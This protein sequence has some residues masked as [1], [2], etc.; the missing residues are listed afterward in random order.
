MNGHV[1]LNICSSGMRNLSIYGKLR[2]GLKPTDILFI[3]LIHPI[4]KGTLLISVPSPMVQLEKIAFE[5]LGNVI[6]RSGAYGNEKIKLDQH[7]VLCHSKS[8][9]VLSPTQYQ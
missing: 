8:L 2:S 3:R 9:L 6:S 7:C 1:F 4:L 5:F